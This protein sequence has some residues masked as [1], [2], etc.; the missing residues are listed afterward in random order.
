[1]KL[2]KDISFAEIFFSQIN[3]INVSKVK[4]IYCYFTEKTS[5]DFRKVKV[6]VEIADIK[7]LSLTK[8]LKDIFNNSLPWNFL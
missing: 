3:V 4:Q 6:E 1:M 2:Y 7:Q 8:S 5:M